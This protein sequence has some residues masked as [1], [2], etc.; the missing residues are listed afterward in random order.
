VYMIRNKR[1]TDSSCVVVDG[2]PE[3]PSSIKKQFEMY[4][5]VFINMSAQNDIFLMT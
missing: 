1:V 2:Q 3:S 4:A 5:C